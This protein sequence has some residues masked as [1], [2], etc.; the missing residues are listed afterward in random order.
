MLFSGLALASLLLHVVATEEGWRPCP[1]GHP[2][3]DPACERPMD[4]IVPVTPGSFYATKITCR[5]CPYSTDGT[6]TKHRT[7]HGD[8]VLVRL[9]PLQ[10]R[11]YLSTT[12]I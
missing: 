7:V 6:D 1:D 12:I 4:D 5:N 3:D 10:F 11:S 9:C 2:L 8:Q